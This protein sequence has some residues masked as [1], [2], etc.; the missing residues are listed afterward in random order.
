MP[1][2]PLRVEPVN[3]CRAHDAEIVLDRV[4]ARPRR[5]VR[6]ATVIAGAVRIMGAPPEIQRRAFEQQRS[7][8]GQ[9][10]FHTGADWGC[11][12]WVDPFRQC[13]G[14]VQMAKTHPPYAPEYRHRMVE[15][16]PSGRT[17]VERARALEGLSASQAASSNV[18]SM[19]GAG[20]MRLRRRRD[21]EAIAAPQP[22]APGCPLSARVRAMLRYPSAPRP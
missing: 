9:W 2:C 12:V 20:L 6:P 14:G 1:R 8:I 5:I 4:S 18:D 17:P 21:R 19:R 22:P 15:R 13:A 16:V 10:N 7:G 11:T 3:D